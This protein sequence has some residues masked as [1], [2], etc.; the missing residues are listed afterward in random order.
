M[1]TCT[2][3]CISFL[4][5]FRYTIS[6]YT[7]FGNK[8][9]NVV[10]NSILKV[11]SSVFFLILFTHELS[12]YYYTYSFSLLFGRCWLKEEKYTLTIYKCFYGLDWLVVIIRDER[13]G[14]AKI[15][16]K[17][18]LIWTISISVELWTENHNKKLSHERERKKEKKRNFHAY[19]KFL[20]GKHFPF[21]CYSLHHM[22]YFMLGCCSTT[23]WWS[24]QQI[25]KKEMMILMNSGK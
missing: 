5:S 9:S 20:I 11:F 13:W 15:V 7:N 2:R 23:E 18:N 24:D 8:L 21:I 3:S 6:V 17:V 25:G 14:S 12:Y 10:F 22:L 4:S 1:Y 16:H 19:G